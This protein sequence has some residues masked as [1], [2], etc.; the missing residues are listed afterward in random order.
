L[1]GTDDIILDEF[2]E[3]IRSHSGL[4]IQIGV[5]PM[6]SASRESVKHLKK[7]A[8]EDKEERRCKLG[9]DDNPKPRLKI[10]IHLNFDARA[11]ECQAFLDVPRLA[12]AVLRRSARDGRG[13]E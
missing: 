13:C 8:Q 12:L 6:D 1:G 7:R 4:S 9:T 3:P 10:G 5:S 2:F 11:K